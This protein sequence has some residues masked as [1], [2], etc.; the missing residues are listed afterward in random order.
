MHSTLLGVV[1]CLNFD[2][3]FYLFFVP[4]PGVFHLF[5]YLL[6]LYKSSFNAKPKE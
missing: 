6:K 1:Y 2:P 3:F 5:I 4:L